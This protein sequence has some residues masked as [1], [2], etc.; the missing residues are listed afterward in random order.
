MGNVAVDKAEYIEKRLEEIVCERKVHVESWSA[1]AGGC[2]GLAACVVDPR[3]QD[4]P[5]GHHSLEA[6][7][8]FILAWRLGNQLREQRETVHVVQLLCLRGP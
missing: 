6:G 1:A 8:Y 5:L 2:W 3:V 7:L 4:H